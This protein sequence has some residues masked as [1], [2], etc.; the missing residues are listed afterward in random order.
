MDNEADVQGLLSSIPAEADLNVSVH[1]GYKT[2][3]RQVSRAPMHKA[4]R[5]LPE[6]E[7]TAIGKTGRMTGKDIRLSYPVNIRSN[8]SL[9]DPCDV[10]EKL[11]SAY[12]YFVS[13]G[14]IEP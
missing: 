5:N 4:L 2:R 9:L 7:V 10:R 13:N 8:G 3:K 14:K 6:G 11:R 1:I 12:D